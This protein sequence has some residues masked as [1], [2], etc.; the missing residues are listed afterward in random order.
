M[1]LALLLVLRLTPEATDVPNKQPQLAADGQRVILTY[2]VGNTIQVARS[3][4]GGKSF[5]APIVVS[6]QGKLSLGMH[7]GPRVAITAQAIV[8][9]AV[10]GEKGRGADGDLVAW[11]STDGGKSWSAP[12]KVNDVSGAAREGLHSMAAGD[13]TLFATWL[14]LREKGTRLYGSVSHDGGATWSNNM[15]VYQSPS[16]TICQCCHPTATVSADGKI[17]V[18]FRNERDGARDLYVVTSADQGRTFGAAEK[19]G[20]GTWMINACPMD[21]GGLL[22]TKTGKVVSVWRREKTVYSSGVG[23]DEVVVGPGKDPALAEGQKGIVFAW[24]SPTGLQA[25]IP[26]ANEPLLLDPAGSSVQLLRT[27]DGKI[28]AAWE[29]KGAIVVESLP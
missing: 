22:T 29:S 3:D 27:A 2:G 18:M 25:K 1:L 15:L 26:G 13:N 10:V 28:L 9:S 4:D 16:G 20:R 17:S 7:R 8:V 19:L 14:D 24:T 5:S 21:G 12:I 6:S 11:R 23:T